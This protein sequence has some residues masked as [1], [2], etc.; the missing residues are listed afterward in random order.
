M[1]DGS[2][3]G[4]TQL[5]AKIEGLKDAAPKAVAKGLYVG[6]LK[7]EENA[8]R[9]IMSGDKHG[10]VYLKGKKKTIRHVASAPGE[11][12]ANDTGRLVNSIRTEAGEDVVR[13]SAGSGAV[14]YATA[15]EF[16]TNKMAPRPF[17]GPALKD[18]TPFIVEQVTKAVQ[19]TL[20]KK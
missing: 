14:K 17:M 18:A 12:P 2:I 20:A 13:I 5:L 8:K 6:G 15:L 7:V 4:L 1:S 10:R 16:G 19:E 9:S 3:K 11:A